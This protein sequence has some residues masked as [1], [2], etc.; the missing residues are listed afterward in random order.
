MGMNSNSE[1]EVMTM[2]RIWERY[3][4]RCRTI[5]AALVLLRK[6][7]TKDAEGVLARDLEASCHYLS[8]VD[9]SPSSDEESDESSQERRTSHD[10]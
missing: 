1:T 6:G 5:V 9:F 7:N 2:W 3:H 8:H 10:E 4:E